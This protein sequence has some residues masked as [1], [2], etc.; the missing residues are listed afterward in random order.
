MNR[1]IFITLFILSFATSAFA[2]PDQ[3]NDRYWV[4][5]FEKEDQTTYIKFSK[6]VVPTS[7]GSETINYLQLWKFDHRSG[8]CQYLPSKVKWRGLNTI[9]LT[10]N[11]QWEFNYNLKEEK[12]YLQTRKNSLTEYRKADL[13]DNPK[14]KCNQKDII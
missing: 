3:I 1:I 4:H 9:E 13:G 10:E 5:Y 11:I 12:L 8:T 6:I 14:I 2:Q 7:D